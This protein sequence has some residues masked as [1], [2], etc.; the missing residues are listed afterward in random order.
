MATAWRRRVGTDLCT[1]GTRHHYGERK[2]KAFA[3][4][5]I[6]ARCGLWMLP[7]MVARSQWLES[8]HWTRQLA[9]VRQCSYGAVQRFQSRF[10]L[11][12]IRSSSLA[13][14]M[15]PPDDSSSLPG[16]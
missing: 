1:S 8:E 11:L 5:N 6:Q 4:S 16:T 14:L 9:S 7:V 15:I 13:W 12:A 2:T 10:V 3:R